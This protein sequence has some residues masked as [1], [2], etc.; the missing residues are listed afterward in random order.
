[1]LSKPTKTTLTSS[2]QSLDKVDFLILLFLCYSLKIVRA[3]NIDKIVSGTSVS[4]TILLKRLT[5]ASTYFTCSMF[6]NNS[7]V[8]NWIHLLKCIFLFLEFRSFEVLPSNNPDLNNNK[9][10][11]NVCNETCCPLI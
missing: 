3:R 9:N 6:I 5:S 2:V 7:H 4:R 10:R 1:M 8:E 11:Y